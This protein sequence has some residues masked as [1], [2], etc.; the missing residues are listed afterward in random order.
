M[1][2]N[3]NDSNNNHSRHHRWVHVPFS[4]AT[5]SLC[6]T[7]IT[8]TYLLFH[9]APYVGYMAVALQDDKD[10]FHMTVN[11]VGWYAGLLGTAFTTGRCLGFVPWKRLRHSQRF[12]WMGGG[13]A[14]RTLLLSLF[15]SALCSLWFGL[16]RDYSSALLARF[17]LGLSNTISGCV[18]RIAIDFER[19]SAVALSNDGKRTL[20][21]APARVLAFMWVSKE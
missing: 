12:F 1:S 13:S 18:K 6:L 19:Q 2:H 3:D 7:S 9:C 21:L 10:L 20:E 14:K 15:L 16:S 17:G 11:S 4:A 5:A 8:H